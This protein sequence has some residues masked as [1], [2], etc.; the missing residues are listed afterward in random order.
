[1]EAVN[2]FLTGASV[3]VAGL[4]VE[5]LRR[6]AAG[7]AGTVVR[8]GDV[9]VGEIYGHKVVNVV[10]DYLAVVKKD[11]SLLNALVSVELLKYGSLDSGWTYL[12]VGQSPGGQLLPSAESELAIT[13]SRYVWYCLYS[14]T[15]SIE[16]FKNTAITRGLLCHERYKSVV[17][18]CCLAQCVVED[19]YS[20][21]AGPVVD[22]CCPGCG[23]IG[24]AGKC[25]RQYRWYN[26]MTLSAIHKISVEVPYLGPARMEC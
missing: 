21:Q 20:G 14:N 11:D 8:G 22:D 5:A 13:G 19:K 4:G 18:A 23:H 15:C 3:G 1:V 12:V 16:Y 10:E 2:G 26:L 9:S 7:A 17:V 6:V 25:R 24:L